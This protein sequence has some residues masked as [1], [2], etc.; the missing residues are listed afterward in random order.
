MFVFQEEAMVLRFAQVP[1]HEPVEQIEHLLQFLVGQPFDQGLYV[2]VIGEFLQVID[3][4]LFIRIPVESEAD[5]T[6]V[7]FNK[8]MGMLGHFFFPIQKK[9]VCR[10]G[11]QGVRRFRPSFPV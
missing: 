1:P 11:E 5:K 10:G 4:G 2:T 7:F 6:V 8:R 9:M 3:K